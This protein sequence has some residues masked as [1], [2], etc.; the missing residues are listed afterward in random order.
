MITFPSFSRWTAVVL[1]GVPVGYMAS[2]DG[3]T[4]LHL[5]DDADPWLREVRMVGPWESNVACQA[6][7]RRAY[8]ARP[9]EI[10]FGEN[11]VMFPGIK[12]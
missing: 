9:Q 12:S 5:K 2:H 4:S 7:I 10:P 8:G 6:A 1:H 3:H 11:I